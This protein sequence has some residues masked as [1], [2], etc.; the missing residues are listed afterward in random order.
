MSSM[1]HQT[2]R[3]HS[4]IMEYWKMHLTNGLRVVQAETLLSA[5]ANKNAADVD[6][7]SVFDIQFYILGM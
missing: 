6:P 1:D 3:G 2:T 4:Q 5:Q 7:E